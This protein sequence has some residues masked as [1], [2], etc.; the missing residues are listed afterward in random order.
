MGLEKQGS[1]PTGKSGYFM[2]KMMNLFHTG[3]YRKYY[4][5]EFAE[6]PTKLLDI[7]CGGGRFIKYLAKKYGKY[8]LF[9][10]DHSEEM[11]NL[12]IKDNLEF[13]KSGKVKI[14][15]GSV[16]Q[17]PYD[18]ESINIVTAHE[19]VQFWPDIDVS[20]SEIYRILQ[21]D[22]CLYIINRYPPEGTKWWELAKLKN[23]S[24]FISAYEKAGF[25]K[26]EVYLTTKKGWIITKSI[27]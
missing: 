13:V 24:D 20:F 9:G 27:K 17:L 2:G 23:E 1:K 22:G 18:N 10:L 21:K 16:T 15:K 7:G 3:F 26:S 14:D 8:K 12:S 19:T 11:V 25:K 6:E 5:N 4:N